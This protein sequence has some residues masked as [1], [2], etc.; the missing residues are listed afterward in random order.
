MING[1]FGFAVIGYGGMGSWHANKIKD[2][3][4]GTAEVV[5]VYD[6]NPQRLD[7]AK[8]RG[9]NTFSSR[10][11]LLSDNRIDLVTVATPNDVH[12]EIVIDALAHGKNVISEKPVTISMADFDEMVAAAE[13]YGLKT[14]KHPILHKGSDAFSRSQR[15][16]IRAMNSR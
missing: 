13:K 7:V 2:N 3:F 5:G 15:G 10:E 12:K 14:K 8:E 11:E 1:K 16:I 4:P 9:F 6:I